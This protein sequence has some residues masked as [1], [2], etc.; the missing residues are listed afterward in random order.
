MNM[1]CEFSGARAQRRGRKGEGGRKERC[2][3]FAHCRSSPDGISK[4]ALSYFDHAQDAQ[5]AM[6]QIYDMAN[7]AHAKSTVVVRLSSRDSQ[8]FTL[9]RLLQQ[10]PARTSHLP[11]VDRMDTILESVRSARTI[12]PRRQGREGKSGS[13]P[14]PD[15]AVD[16]LCAK[17]WLI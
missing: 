7:R 5:S 1:R 2:G 14:Y 15:L 11:K 9:V 3:S 13:G 16:W 17:G 6:K 4:I 8:R 12:R 10:K